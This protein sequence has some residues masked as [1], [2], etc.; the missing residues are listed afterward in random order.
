MYKISR[1][2][3]FNKWILIFKNN[4]CNY[5]LKRNFFVTNV[6]KEKS[7][8]GYT[9]ARVM[10]SPR[11]LLIETRIDSRFKDEEGGEAIVE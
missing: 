7:A 4:S 1:T 2:F 6:N 10:T 5:D 8:E 3:S 9:D 11:N